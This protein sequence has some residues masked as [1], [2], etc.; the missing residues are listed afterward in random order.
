[1]LTPEE[2]RNPVATTNE[3]KWN[4]LTA[5]MTGVD[6]QRYMTHLT[7]AIK[8]SRFVD[9]DGGLDNV[10][11]LASETPWNVLNDYFILRVLR[12][13]GR[14][15]SRS[16]RKEFERFDRLVDGTT[17]QPR[18]RTCLGETNKRL[19]W[20]LGRVYVDRE[21]EPQRK[22]IAHEMVKYIKEAFQSSLETY[23]WMDNETRQL[24]KLKLEE[25][26]V[27]TA[28]PDWLMTD[29]AEKYFKDFYGSSL[30]QGPTALFDEHLHLEKRS[31]QF[32]F[33]NFE[34]PNDRSLWSMT[35]QTVNAYYSPSSNEI[36]FPASVLR[37]PFLF[38]YDEA[39]PKLDRIAMKALTYSAL[40]A[41]IGHE[42][43]H[44]FDDSGRHFDHRGL[45]E[46]WFTESSI[47]GFNKAASCI[48]QQYSEYSVMVEPHSND[49]DAGAEILNI[50]GQLT[51][52]ENIADNGGHNLSWAAFQKTLL[53]EGEEDFLSKHPLP[54][55]ELTTK[56]I[57]MLGF[58]HIWCSVY[59]DESLRQQVKS[60]PHSPGQFRVL[61]VFANS[62]LF[63]ESFSCSDDSW[64]MR[65]KK[66]CSVW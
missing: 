40:G 47:E 59:R 21:V 7:P 35:P 15:L 27:K 3:M 60:D 63:E 2:S 28:Y 25:M 49:G 14:N 58:S 5:R 20:I 53:D 45:L 56:Q 8:A 11:Q 64:I 39:T 38:V 43:S 54:G 37:E 18:W 9:E 52:G 4:E 16:W 55:L 62:P 66:L 29:E 17:A 41:V 34:Q 31:V 13:W 30:S 42:I 61:G 10:N 26:G 50:S 1:M 32:E 36:V 57:F 48:D 24:A 44:G 33:S 51:L 19:G 23:Q 46:D 6:M 22:Q 65:N 12:K